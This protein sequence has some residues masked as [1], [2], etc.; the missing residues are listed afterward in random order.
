MTRFDQ[1]DVLLSQFPFSD[2]SATKLRPIIVISREQRGAD[3]IVLSC[4]SRPNPN[5][6]NTF[7]IGED[8]PYFDA[9]GLNGPTAVRFKMPFTIEARMVRRKLGRIAADDLRPIVQGLI[10]Y[11]TC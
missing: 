1:G 10:D 9:T 3:I 2:G 4:S 7:Y 6:P 8:A 11:I 5:D